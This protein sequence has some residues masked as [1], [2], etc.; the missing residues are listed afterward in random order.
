[1]II[2]DPKT[3]KI[4]KSI[5]DK[6]DQKSKSIYRAITFCKKISSKALL[7][8]FIDSTTCLTELLS[9]KNA[10]MEAETEDQLKLYEK[11]LNITIKFVISEIKNEV[12]FNSEHQLFHLFRLVSPESHKL[13][14]N[15]YRNTLVQVGG[16]LCPPP[17]SVNSLVSQLFYNLKRIEH[18]LIK[19]IYLHHELIRIHPFVD[20]N[21]RTTRIAKNWI[22]MYNLYPPIF[23][24]DSD[25]K[26]EYISS[27]KE[28]FKSL[29][30][31]PTSWQKETENFFT[32]ELNRVLESIN[33]IQLNLDK[34]N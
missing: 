20:G 15:K 3:I 5:L 25:G 18:P 31:N 7:D 24:K 29:L 8:N 4:D 10:Q 11:N 1:M 26:K 2:I 14:P 27:L 28:S 30:S 19:A 6:I 23:I 9:I 12:D 22:L 34:L 21:G 16:H 33:N 17:G 32:Q 13:H